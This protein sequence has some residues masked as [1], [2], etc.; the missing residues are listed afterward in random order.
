MLTV[1]TREAAG[2][3]FETGEGVGRQPIA[4]CRF[5]PLLGEQGF[6]VE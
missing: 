4:P 6:G 5:V 2:F 1:L 3:D